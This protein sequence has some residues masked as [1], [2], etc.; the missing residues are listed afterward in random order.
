MGSPIDDNEVENGH[1]RTPMDDGQGSEDPSS[2]TI[3]G[4]FGDA[5]DVSSS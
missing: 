2:Q 3:E 1:R 4:I 5:A